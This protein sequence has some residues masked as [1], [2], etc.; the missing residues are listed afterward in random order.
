MFEFASLIT[1][2]LHILL[3]MFV[4]LRTNSLEVSLQHPSV[5]IWVPKKGS[6]LQFEPALEEGRMCYLSRSFTGA[7]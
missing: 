6:Y 2:F 4:I 1:L 5:P 3:P 7:P